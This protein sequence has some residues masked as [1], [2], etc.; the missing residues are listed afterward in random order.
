MFGLSVP[1]V[2]VLAMGLVLEWLAW[3]ICSKAGLPGPLGLVALI[4]AGLVVLLFLLAL[5]DWPALGTEA[6]PGGKRIQGTVP[7]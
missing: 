5:V 1:E 3:R 4:P 7:C 2:L 6:T